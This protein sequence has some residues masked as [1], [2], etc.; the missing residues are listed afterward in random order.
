MNL[1]GVQLYKILSQCIKTC[2]NRQKVRRLRSSAYYV[3]C[4]IM[5]AAQSVTTTTMW[6]LD[7]LQTKLQYPQFNEFDQSLADL[8]P[9]SYETHVPCDT[10][11]T[12]H[13]EAQNNREVILYMFSRAH[14]LIF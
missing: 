2:Q 4:I 12:M 6:I 11:V 9:N 1:K 13:I 14:T 3:I 5:P 10:T 7:P 8:R